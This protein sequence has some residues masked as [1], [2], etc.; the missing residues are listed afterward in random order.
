M[1]R[2]M[3]RT[4]PATGVDKSTLAT[5]IRKGTLALAVQAACCPGCR[6]LKPSRSQFMIAQ[7]WMSSNGLTGSVGHQ[8]RAMQALPAP[9]LP[10]DSA[11]FRQHEVAMQQAS[12]GADLGRSS[13]ERTHVMLT[14]KSCQ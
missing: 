4:V 7:N 1:Y 3:G 8:L 9:P 6:N 11:Q 12:V 14:M 13:G 10:A 2:K 5:A